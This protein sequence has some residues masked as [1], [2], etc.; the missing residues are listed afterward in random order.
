MNKLERLTATLLL[1]Q[2]RPHTSLEIAR[3]FEVSKRTV[4]RDVQAL[5]EMGVPVVAR[6]GPGGGYSLPDDYALSPLPLTTHEAF[7]LMLALGSLAQWADVPFAPEWASLQAKLAALLPEQE[8][9]RAAQLLATIAVELPAPAARAPHLEALMAATRGGAWVRVEYV[10]AGRTST[11][12]LLPRQLTTRGGLWYCRAYSHEHDAERTYRVDRMTAL[13]PTA[14]PRPG[15]APPTP[16]PYDAPEHPEVRA[17]LSARGASQVESE[18]DLSQVLVR[19]PDGT[20]WLV[21]RCPPSELDWFARYFAGLGAEVTVHGP[22]ELRQRLAALGQALA[23][24]YSAA[25]ENR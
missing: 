20:G 24:R 14:N 3:R 19:A 2:E 23:E 16:R 22:P 11:Q 21:L 5:C 7:L 13:A 8:R 18:P 17:T 1:L 12:H 25:P 9:A 6:E 10:S 15:H 4:L